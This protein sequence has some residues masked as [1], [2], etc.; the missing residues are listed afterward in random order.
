MQIYVFMLH[1][2]Q[3]SVRLYVHFYIFDN[4]QK[5]VMKKII[6]VFS[7]FLMLIGYSQSFNKNFKD[8]SLRFDFIFEG[9]L[10]K[11][12]IKLDTIK[13]IAKWNGRKVNLDKNLLQGD[14]EIN[15]YDLR[16]NKIIYTQSFSTLY[17]EWLT[18]KA[19]KTTVFSTEQVL[20][21]PLPKYNFR[22]QIN[23]FHNNIAKE[24]FN[25]SFNVNDLKKIKAITADTV[26][27]TIKKAT[28]NKNVI[29]LTFVAEGFTMVDEQKFYDAVNKSVQALFKYP[30]FKKY[31]DQFNITAVFTLSKDSGVTI[32]SKH[33]YK[34][35]IAH[36]TF[37]TF[38]A[39]RYLTPSKLFKLHDA[40]ASTQADHIIILAN[41][42]QYGGA[43]IYNGYTIATLFGQTF[44]EV[45]VHEFGH[46]FA[47][48]GDEYFYANDIFSDNAHQN[49]VEPWVK[50]NTTLVDFQSK[51]KNKLPENTI[52][53]TPYTTDGTDGL[54][55][56]LGIEGGKV[57]IPHQD[58][59]MHTNTAKDF[60]SVC[61]DAIEELILHYTVQ[62]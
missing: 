51:W 23:F 27:K 22:V 35:T 43:G 34:N 10:N 1:C 3:K 8:Q 36:A 44:D 12:E 11:T 31:E 54:G 17:Q 6:T 19:A 61:S 50:N 46:S 52:I 41:S 21:I 60:C 29:N 28:S 32:P 58:C 16:T 49:T 56:Y 40:L 53:P 38:G 62:K 13:R 5:Y 48:L 42:N 39:E 25:Q 26:F 7:L 57:Y 30:S 9:N 18:Q 2:M 4:Y 47:G 15:V 45:V 20:Y 33:I 14:A 59:R 37:D 24:V 55:V